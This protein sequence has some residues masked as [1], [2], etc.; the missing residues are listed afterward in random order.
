M[1]NSGI[2]LIINQ[3]NGKGYVGQSVNIKKRWSV[4]KTQLNH[5]KHVNTYLQ[6]AW[7]KYGEEKFNF[8]ILEKCDKDA[9]NDA[10]IFWIKHL[11]TYKNGYNMD[12]GGHFLDQEGA[13]NCQYGKGFSGIAFVTI[14]TS[15]TTKKGYTWV[16][17]RVINGHNIRKELTSLLKLKDWVIS[18]NYSW[19]IVDKEKAQKS[20]I[21]DKRDD[22]EAIS[23]LHNSRTRHTIWDS[24]KVDFDKSAFKEKNPYR[25]SFRTMYNSRKVPIGMFNDFV[26]C[27]IINLLIKE[28]SE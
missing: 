7:N 21:R 1:D 17:K 4:H 27:E 25:K 19:D 24:S 16:Y 14:N 22:K 10:E 11:N 23:K 3:T 9:L 15:S 5:Q 20:F 13:K 18:N 2:Y 26:S 8:L 6:N 28:F 12:E